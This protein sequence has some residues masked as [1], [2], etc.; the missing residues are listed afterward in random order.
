MYTLL[1][2][3]V[4]ACVPFIRWFKN[5]VKIKMQ[6]V[7]GREH[8]RSHHKASSKTKTRFSRIVLVH[9]SPMNVVFA[10]M[11]CE[12]EAMRSHVFSAVGGMKKVSLHRAANCMVLVVIAALLTASCT[13]HNTIHALIPVKPARIG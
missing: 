5:N 8:H 7:D 6:H 2:Q 1:N 12:V 9:G 13:K 3:R 4:R 11:S 10:R